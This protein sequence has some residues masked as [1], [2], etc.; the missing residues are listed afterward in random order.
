MGQMRKLPRFPQTI[1][2]DLPSVGPCQ[3][4]EMHTGKDGASTL[5]KLSVKE[6]GKLSLKHSMMCA[7]TGR[8]AQ[9]CGLPIDIQTTTLPE[10]C[11]SINA[12]EAL[13]ELPAS[14]Q[15]CPGQQRGEGRPF[16]LEGFAI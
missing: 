10:N 2:E 16:A 1:L 11:I 9:L 15:P 13:I 8:C 7:L 12:Q 3:V 4:M 6:A 5:E 14:S